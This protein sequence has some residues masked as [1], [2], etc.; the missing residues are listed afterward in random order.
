MVPKGGCRLAIWLTCLLSA[1]LLSTDAAD[2]MWSAQPLSEATLQTNG[3]WE[4]VK[5]TNITLQLDNEAEVLVSYFL[6]TIAMWK[7]SMKE[8]CSR[9]KLPEALE[10]LALRVSNE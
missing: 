10:D 2:L 4:P 7:L 5:D 9:K 8:T 6:S 3:L 1:A